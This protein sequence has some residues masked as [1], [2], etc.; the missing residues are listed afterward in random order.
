LYVEHRS[1]VELSRRLNRII[2]WRIE[3]HI[4]A[5]ASDRLK[6][7]ASRKMKHEF[8]FIAAASYEISLAEIY[9]SGRQRREIGSLRVSARRLKSFEQPCGLRT[10]GIVACPIRVMKQGDDSAAC[11]SLCFINYDNT[12]RRRPKRVM[13]PVSQCNA[14]T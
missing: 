4:S 2:I 11:L 9:R 13:P 3:D 8:R 7:L 12:A 14:A 5:A 1:V 10:N 6:P